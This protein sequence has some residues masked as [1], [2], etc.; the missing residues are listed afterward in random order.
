MFTYNTM[1]TFIGVV[2]MQPL[3]MISPASEDERRVEEFPAELVDYLAN[4]I[5]KNIT[6][7]ISSLESSMNAIIVAMAGS[8][9]VLL[10]APELARA[11]GYK[12]FANEIMS[13]EEFNNLS[14][15][16]IPVVIDARPLDN[17]RWWILMP[18]AVCDC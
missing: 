14:R 9:N 10:H 3:H 8:T 18:K 1:Q 4:L 15:N 5:D 16:V 7:E 13:P 11:A 17:I 6:L 2:G 12:D